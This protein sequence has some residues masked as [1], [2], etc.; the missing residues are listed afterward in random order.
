MHIFLIFPFFFIKKKTKKQKALDL[1]PPISM[2]GTVDFERRE[3]AIIIVSLFFFPS[4]SS[5]PKFNCYT[6][7]WSTKRGRPCSCV[8]VYI[9]IFICIS[10][11][12]LEAIRSAACWTVSIFSAPSSSSVIENS[13][14]RAIL[15]RLPLPMP[16]A[17]TYVMRIYIDVLG[18][19]EL[20]GLLT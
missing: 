3:V 12:I 4:S 7:V 2:V 19:R 1:T 9:Y 14:S 13:S 5:F 20:S 16:I 10:F 18:A 8:C 15:H 17:Y 11:H 6:Q